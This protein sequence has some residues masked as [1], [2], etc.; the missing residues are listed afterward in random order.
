M[1]KRVHL[2]ISGRVQGVFYRESTRKEAVELGVRG[3]VRN[4][5]DGRV[6]ALAEGPPEAVDAF[7][8]WC[9]EGPA[10]A[11]VDNVDAKAVGDGE[12]LVGFAVRPTV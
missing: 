4:L 12:S 9:H 8:A 7:V 1:T 3:W 11:R 10:A 2:L 5:S 6:E